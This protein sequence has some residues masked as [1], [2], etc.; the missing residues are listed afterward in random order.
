VLS[1]D[2]PTSQSAPREASQKI[3]APKYDQT[4]IYALVDLTYGATQTIS[5]NRTP[6][7]A[8]LTNESSAAPNDLIAAG[9][10]LSVSVFEPGTA[11]L[12]ETALQ[13]AAQ[14]NAAIP[15]SPIAPAQSPTGIGT[16]STLPSLIVSLDGNL[17]FPYAGTV[18]VAGL[19]ADAAAAAIRRAL[20]GKAI[21]PQVTVTVVTSHA[22]SVSVL[23]EVRTPGR[24]QLAAHNERLLDLL[25]LAGGPV[26]PA[27]DLALAVYRGDQRVEVSLSRVMED[28]AQNIRLAPEDRVVVLD[29]PRT[30]SVFGAMSQPNTNQPMLDNSITLADAISKS[31]GLDTLS[32]NAR[33]VL[34]FRFERP[35][36]ARAL[37]VT[38][39]PA[40]KGVPIVYRLNFRKPEG[41]FVAGNFAIEPEDML[42]VPRSDL[43]EAAKF[44]NL[45]NT[46]T[47]IGYNARVTAQSIVP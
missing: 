32:A 13:Q 19:K 22:N 27:P 20:H 26:K 36:V 29:R 47:Q 18:H 4:G 24:F 2:G 46:V 8:G 40:A 15:L 38:I 7:L 28:P 6:A 35:E 41:M 37:G 31:G 33:S 21:D 3:L 45:V 25:S 17:L 42:Y 1:Q 10:Q 23:G 34:L 5:A 11:G 9:D 30:Y 39:P 16:A 44:F 43:F 12:F 14:S